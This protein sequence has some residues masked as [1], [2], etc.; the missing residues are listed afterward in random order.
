MKVTLKQFAGIVKN[1]A[2][3]YE[4]V[5]LL[6]KAKSI[7]GERLNS[8]L[9]EKGDQKTGIFG[10]A[11]IFEFLTRSNYENLEFG[12]PSEKGWDIKGKKDNCIIRI[13]VKTTSEFAE[14]R[15][16]SPIHY[17]WDHLY[18]VSLDKFFIPNGIWLL[19]NPSILDW[20]I[21]MKGHRVIKSK[22]M[23]HPEKQ[24]FKGSKVIF[25]PNYTLDVFKEFKDRMNELYH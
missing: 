15:V 6:Q 24:Q 19:D 12:T 7:S 9:P 3:T 16:I 5:E 25:D 1:Y 4:K 20:K 21:D 17:G 22:K 18:L 2:E 8:F 23:K 14:S 13:Q 11:F 10:E